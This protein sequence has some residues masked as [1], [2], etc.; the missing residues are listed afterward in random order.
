[1]T[2]KLSSDQVAEIRDRVHKKATPLSAL[3]REFEMSTSTLSNIVQG[4]TYK[5]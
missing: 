3:A 4:K 5:E 1:M 2:R